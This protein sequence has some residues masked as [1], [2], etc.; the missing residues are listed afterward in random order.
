MKGAIKRRAVR[1]LILATALLAL[2]A[3]I[4]YATIPG[5]NG[6]INGCYEKRTGILRVIDAE[7]GKACLSIE[8]PISWSQ[9]GPKGDQGLQ[10]PKGEKGD[11][12]DKGDPGTPADPAQIAQLQQQVAALQQ[13]LNDLQKQNNGQ[14]AR[15]AA[16]EGA[17]PTLTADLQSRLAE[18]AA[19]T[20]SS[21]GGLG[22]RLGS[23][24]SAF[25]EMKTRMDELMGWVGG[26]EPM[27]PGC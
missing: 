19:S 12:G 9:Q 10:G 8:T 25:D 17:F 4:A 24:E 2:G 5:S 16:L 6:T 21:L 7:A 11:K 14:V 26:R 20:S 15:L 1:I 27:G 23:L 18:L 3:G 22:A 13:A